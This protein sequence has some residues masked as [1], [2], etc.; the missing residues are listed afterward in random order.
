LNHISVNFMQTRIKQTTRC[1]TERMTR[2]KRSEMWS[3]SKSNKNDRGT[4][5]PIARNP[6]LQI[7]SLLDDPALR[8]AMGLDQAPAAVA[9]VAVKERPQRPFGRRQLLEAA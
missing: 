6:E 5:G 9:P 7:R 2:R 8:R 3:W 1:V 4:M